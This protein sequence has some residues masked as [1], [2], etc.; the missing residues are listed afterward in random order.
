MPD[1]S[2]TL[3]RQP[4]PCP[5]SRRYEA[6]NVELEQTTLEQ[7]ARAIFAAAKKPDPSQQRD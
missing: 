6:V 2:G 5:G 1:Q 3:A 7:V 4:R